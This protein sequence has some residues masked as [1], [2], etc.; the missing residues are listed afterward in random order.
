MQIAEVHVK[1]RNLLN[2]RQD[3]CMVLTLA[4]TGPISA[5]H[6]ELLIAIFQNINRPN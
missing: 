4:L 5:V 6:D 2:V 1:N 3:L